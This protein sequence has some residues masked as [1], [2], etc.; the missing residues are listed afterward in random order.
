[1]K[2]YALSWD[3]VPER[4]ICAKDDEEAGNIVYAHHLGN[5][6]RGTVCHWSWVELPL[7]GKR[8]DTLSRREYE[9]GAIPPPDVGMVSIVDALWLHQL[10]REFVRYGNTFAWARGKILALEKKLDETV[11]WGVALIEDVQSDLRILQS[12]AWWWEEGPQ[13]LSPEPA[14]QGTRMTPVTPI[15]AAPIAY[16]AYGAVTDH[17]NYQGLPMPKWEDLPPRIQEAW[18]AACGAV[19]LLCSGLPLPDAEPA[20]RQAR[21]VTNPSRRAY[22]SAPDT[23]IKDGLCVSPEGPPVVDACSTSSSD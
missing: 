13:A 5:V 7:L 23:T 17:K 16:D 21:E 3:K 18:R 11:S 9:L 22:A 1:M 12:R 2:F 14:T 19:I 8:A 6:E 10:R 20:A 15:S 4:V